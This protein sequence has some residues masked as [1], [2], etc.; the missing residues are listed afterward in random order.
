MVF[1]HFNLYPHKTVLENVTLAPIKVLGIDKK[2]AEKT[3]Q[4]IWN[5]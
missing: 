1:Q 5:L 3:A 2:E 4:N